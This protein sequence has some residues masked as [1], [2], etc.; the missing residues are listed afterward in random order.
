ML[1]G[2]KGTV[3]HVTASREGYDKPLEFAIARDEISGLSVDDYFFLR[4]GIAYIHLAAF[5]ENT[6]EELTQALRKLGDKDLKGLILDLRG[7]PG[8]LLQAAVDVSDHFLEKRQLI[9][10]HNGRHAKEERYYAKRGDHGDDYPI[11]VL[12]N[13]NSA[14]AAEIV[15]GALQD[16]DRALVMGETSFGKGLVTT[17]RRGSKSRTTR[18]SRRVSQACPRLKTSWLGPRSTWRARATST[19]SRA[20]RRP[21]EPRPSG[22]KGRHAPGRTPVLLRGVDLWRWR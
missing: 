3:V 19:N 18:W 5:S 21:S 2:P 16:H 11:V 12:I 8:G 22:A 7:N 6:G 9:V 13:H 20:E 4:P 15:T 17:R 14:S 1:K 10:Y